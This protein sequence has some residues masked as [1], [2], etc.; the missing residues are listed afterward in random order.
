MAPARFISRLGCVCA[1]D[2][3]IAALEQTFSEIMR[4]HEGLRTVFPAVN[5]QPIQVIQ[6][7]TTFKLPLVDLRELDDDEREQE[8]ARLAQA[9]TVRQFDLTT[10]PLAR[11][12]LLR[13][14]PR[15]HILI[16]RCT[17]SSATG[18]RSK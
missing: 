2:L 5:Q 11:M 12:N 8:A 14:S 3:N 9:Q 7:P 4:R 13:L 1:G 18:S 6:S 16:A 17:T 15:E 10:G